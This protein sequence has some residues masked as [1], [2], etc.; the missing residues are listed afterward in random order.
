MATNFAGV[1]LTRR[2][3]P[4][5]H[6]KVAAAG[7]SFCLTFFEAV[8]VALVEQHGVEQQGAVLADRDGGITHVA[9]LPQKILYPARIRVE[10][11]ETPVRWI[12]TRRVESER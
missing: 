3:T 12:V 5:S 11:R 8:G 6:L 2:Q 7:L 9:I 10:L 1:G 4:N